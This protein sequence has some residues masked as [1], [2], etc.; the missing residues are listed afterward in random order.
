MRIVK[1]F[2]VLSFVLL[3]ISYLGAPPVS[4]TFQASSQSYRGITF[5]AHSDFILDVRSINNQDNFSLYVF[6][7]MDTAQVMTHG[8]LS[9]TNPLFELAEIIE[10]NDIIII[11][12]Q[13]HYSVLVTT[14]SEEYI[15]VIITITPVTPKLNIL[16]L[17]GISLVLGMILFSIGRIIE[18]RS[19]HDELKRVHSNQ[20]E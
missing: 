4:D 3:V 20:G 18:T 16:V 17:S 1:T 13:E 5:M 7:Y 15:D 2:V 19:F 11:P 8:N 6:D 10:Y 12:S 9:N 14:L